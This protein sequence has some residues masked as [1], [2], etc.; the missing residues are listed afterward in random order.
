MTSDASGTRRVRTERKDKNRG[1]S[2]YLRRS[3]RRPQPKA[4]HDLLSV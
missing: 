2:G 1:E 3:N 4:R